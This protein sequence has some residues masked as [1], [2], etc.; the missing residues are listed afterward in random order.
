M[1][2]DSKVTIHVGWAAPSD[3]GFFFNFHINMYG[4]EW[5]ET[6]DFEQ[7]ISLDSFLS[8][9]ASFK[10]VPFPAYTSKEQVRIGNVM[11]NTTTFSS[12]DIRMLCQFAKILENWINEIFSRAT[13]LDNE[14][15]QLLKQIFFRSEEKLLKFDILC[16]IDDSKA[17]KNVSKGSILKNIKKRFSMQP[18]GT[19]VLNEKNL[20]KAARVNS[21]AKTNKEVVIPKKRQ[22]IFQGIVNMATRSV[23][24]GEKVSAKEFDESPEDEGDTAGI[25]DP[26]SPQ[27]PSAATDAAIKQSALLKIEINRGQEIS[28]G[29]LVYDI[30][31]KVVGKKNPILYSTSQ[32]YSNFKRLFEKL[33]EINEESSDVSK[34]KDGRAPYAHFIH[35][36]SVPFPGVS[37]KSYL[38]GLNDSDLSVR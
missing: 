5:H 23:N 37:I 17:Q 6:V 29:V 11:S 19:L 8:S 26:K 7:L 33:K 35:M 25:K 15:R 28:N 14:P 9:S 31:L 22:S 4:F 20:A 36:L 34:F 18:T 10:H 12:D 16:D 24:G 13:E 3:D 2:A 32:R 30:N 1:A 38:V 27:V 21:D